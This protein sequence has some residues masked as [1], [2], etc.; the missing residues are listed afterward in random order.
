MQTYRH[1]Q[2]Y[3]NKASLDSTCTT[4][5]QSRDNTRFRRYENDLTLEE[6]DLLLWRECVCFNL[7]LLCKAW[8]FLWGNSVM[9][10]VTISQRK[11]FATVTLSCYTVTSVSREVVLPLVLF[12]IYWD[13]LMRHSTSTFFKTI[14]YYFYPNFIWRDKDECYMQWSLLIDLNY[15]AFYI[16]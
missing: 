3:S 13:A 1:N 4:R 14:T 11:W 7:R 16:I 8:T 6:R 12:S 10:Y 2:R 15:L 5:G 9:S